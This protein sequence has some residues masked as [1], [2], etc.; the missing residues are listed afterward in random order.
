[1]LTVAVDVAEHRRRDVNR[2]DV[3]G[4]GEEANTGDHADFYVEPTA[5]WFA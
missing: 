4:I 2:E 1:M 3:V 5:L